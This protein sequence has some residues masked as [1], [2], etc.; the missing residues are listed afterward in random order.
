M[1]SGCGRHSVTLRSRLAHSLT[2]TTRLAGVATKRVTLAQGFRMNTKPII[3]LL[4]F[5]TYGVA[6][7]TDEAT[8]L[9]DSPHPNEPKAESVSTQHSVEIDGRTIRYTVTAG[10]DVIRND[11]GDGI[12]LF[13]YTAYVRDGGDTTKRPIL[14]AYNG[15]PGSASIWLHMG[16]LGPRR[17]P[18]VDVEVTGPPPYGVVNNEFSILDVADLVMMDPVGTGYATIEGAGKPE[19]F[20]GVDPDIAV[21][22]QFIVSYITQN[23][24]WKSPKFVLGESYGGIRTGG[25][26]Y[27]LLSEYGMGLNGV[28]LVSPFMDAAAARDRF[29]IDLPHALY[30]PTLAATA[31]YHHAIDDRPGDLA[32]FV[33]EVETFAIDEYAPALMKGTTLGE[34]EKRALITK[35]SGYTGLSE[36]YWENSNLRVPHTHFTQELLRNE[37]VTVGRVDSRF[38]G[39]S[40]N[41]VAERMQYDPFDAGVRPAFKAGFMHYYS[42]DLEF[43][44][45]RDYVVSGGLYQD[46]DWLHTMPDGQETLITNTAVDLATTMTL[47]PPMQV[48]VQQGY[49]DLATPHFVLEYVLNHM[50][51]D[52]S[53]RARVSVEMYEAGHMMYV[54]PPSLVKYKEDLA[55]FIRSNNGTN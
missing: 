53:Q 26:A 17:I 38:K 35:L 4:I 47:Y 51:L 41:R 25:V 10:L 20:W 21:A 42:N 50:D 14:F 18:V 36:Q 34:T 49:F 55:S 24:R 52:E 3:P 46:W 32:A 6:F 30:L 9:G 43:K 16:V 33:D 11:D 37:D 29:E 28:I 23:S 7:G 19:D 45:D 2:A 22:S 5:L 48:L 54:H 1:A 44:K 8:E 13:G 39:R 31:W 15:G 12:G 40:I 27:R